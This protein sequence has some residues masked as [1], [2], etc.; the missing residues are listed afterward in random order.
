MAWTWRVPPAE[1]LPAAVPFQGPVK[2]GGVPF[3]GTGYFKFAILEVGT[4]VWRNAAPSS[5]VDEPGAAVALSV[6][7][8]RFAVLLGD[9]SLQSMAELNASIFSGSE[10]WRTHPRN[11]PATEGP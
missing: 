3:T 1:A 5:G 8:G 4:V 10:P 11:R 6:A 7:A 9:T 2:E